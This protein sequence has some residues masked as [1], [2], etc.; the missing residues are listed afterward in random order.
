[1]PIQISAATNK[2]RRA[3][4][5]DSD[6]VAEFTRRHGTYESAVKRLK[7][8]LRQ[9]CADH[10]VKVHKIEARAKDVGSFVQKLVRLGGRFTDPLGQ[11]QDLVGLR[12]I[13]HTLG[14]IEMVSRVVDAQFDVIESADKLVSLRFDQFGYRSLHKM[15]RLRPRHAA[16]FEWSAFADMLFELQVRTV[17]QHAWAVT[18]QKVQYKRADPLPPAEHRKL[19]RM[20]GLLEMADEQL[21]ELCDGQDGDGSGPRPKTGWAVDL[22]ATGQAGT[23]WNEVL[24]PEERRLLT[25]LTLPICKRI[26]AA[27]RRAGIPVAEEQVDSLRRLAGLWMAIENRLRLEPQTLLRRLDQ[28]AE[29]KYRLLARELRTVT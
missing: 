15:F 16:L 4:I 17:L 25:P 9:L 5:S 10:G 8:L 29:M 18:S 21:Q 13:V 3:H 20:S 26:I 27:G 1:M 11:M 2:R 12:V 6:A 24:T 28:D 14:E 19:A 23:L 7:E 22:Q